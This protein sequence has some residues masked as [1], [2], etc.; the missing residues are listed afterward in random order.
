VTSLAWLCHAGALTNTRLCDLSSGWRRRHHSCRVLSVRSVLRAWPDGR[1]RHM[2]APFP[3]LWLCAAPPC[4]ALS[5]LILPAEC[6]LVVAVKATAQCRVTSHISVCSPSP[7]CL[8]V[9]RHRALFILARVTSLQSYA[10]IST[11]CR[12]RCCG[13]TAGN[14]RRSALTSDTALLCSVCVCVCRAAMCEWWRLCFTVRAR[15]SGICKFTHNDRLFR[16]HLRHCEVFCR[17]RRQ[18]YVFECRNEKHHSLLRAVIVKVWKK[19]RQI[20]PSYL[21]TNMTER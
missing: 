7:P 15:M 4:P 16:I 12:R 19:C 14:W 11:G 2:T 20:R 21:I 8:L 10:R 1:R 6:A 17:R 13:W 9:F 18:L 3:F 5:Q